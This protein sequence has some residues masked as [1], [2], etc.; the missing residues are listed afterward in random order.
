MDPRAGTVSKTR[1]FDDIVLT[2]HETR[3]EP[4]GTFGLLACSPDHA[5]NE[6]EL[7]IVAAMPIG[8]DR[9]QGFCPP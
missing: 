9:F 8:K 4:V 3:K 5:P 6:N 1:G 7:R 2:G